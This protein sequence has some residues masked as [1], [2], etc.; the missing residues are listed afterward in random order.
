MMIQMSGDM[1]PRPS[2]L[3]AVI[4]RNSATLSPPPEMATRTVTSA[5]STGGHASASLD[6]S[7]W[8][9]RKAR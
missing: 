2:V 8:G 3:Q 7:G 6:S 1:R 5:H 4:A 9:M